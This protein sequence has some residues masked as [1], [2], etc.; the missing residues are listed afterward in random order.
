VVLVL[1]TGSLGGGHLGD[2][3]ADC[4][5]VEENLVPALERCFGDAS[6]VRHELADGDAGFTVLGEFGPVGGDGVVVFEQPAVSQEVDT[7]GGDAFGR[8]PTEDEII[9]LQRGPCGVATADGEIDDTLAVSVDDELD[10]GFGTCGD[11][12]FDTHTERLGE[13]EIERHHEILWVG[14]FLPRRNAFPLLNGYR[15]GRVWRWRGCDRP[16]RR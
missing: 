13:T 3:G 12:V 15:K 5:V 16:W 14:A 10:P 6:G 9:G 2:G 11:P 1:C 7:G 4:V 8:R